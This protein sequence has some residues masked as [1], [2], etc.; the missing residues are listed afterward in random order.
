MALDGI[1]GDVDQVAVAGLLQQRRPLIVEKGD[2]VQEERFAERVRGAA[3]LVLPLTGPDPAPGP[4]RQLALEAIAL[5]TGSAIEYAE[6]PEQQGQGLSGRGYFLHQRFLELI[7]NL[8][9]MVT[10]AGVVLQADGSVYTP[11][12]MKRAQTPVGD[13]PPPYPDIDPERAARPPRYYFTEDVW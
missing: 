1:L 4:V 2:P 8:T 7:A 3:V 10:L 5:E 11:V 13:F 12:L 6:F 9:S